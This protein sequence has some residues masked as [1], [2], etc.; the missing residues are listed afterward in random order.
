MTK[1]CRQCQ[2]EAHLAAGTEVPQDLMDAQ[3]RYLASPIGKWME[4]S[5]QRFVR[6]Q[7]GQPDL[8][9]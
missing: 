1:C 7:L 2:V 3:A 5:A 6:D 4:E 9:R 8:E